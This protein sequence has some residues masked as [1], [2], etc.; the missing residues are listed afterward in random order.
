MENPDKIVEFER[1][2]GDCEYHDT[3]EYEQPCHECLNTFT[4]RYSRKPIK[5]KKEKKKDKKK[6]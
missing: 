3:K 2:C 4:R 5:F 1:Y 6:K